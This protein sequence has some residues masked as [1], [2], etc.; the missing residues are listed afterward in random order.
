MRAALW[1]VR[2]VIIFIDDLD[3]YLPH[4]FVAQ[5]LRTSDG[6]CLSGRAIEKSSL[7]IYLIL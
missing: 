4:I 3:S 5:L 6:M 7:T 1:C 2:R